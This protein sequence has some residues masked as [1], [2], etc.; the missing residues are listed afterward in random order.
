MSRI[1]LGAVAARLALLGLVHLGFISLGLPDGLLGPAWRPIRQTFGIPLDALGALLLS[2]TAGYLLS[3]ASSGWVVERIGVGRLL[4]ASGFLAAL[5]L[6]GYAA[7]PAWWVMV[8]L[9][10]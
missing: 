4:A 2:T 10:L 6:L 1:V 8:G 3:S 9:G 7:A 5:G